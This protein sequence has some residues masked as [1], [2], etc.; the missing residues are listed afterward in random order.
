MK[1]TSLDSTESEHCFDEKSPTW[2]C[3]IPTQILAEDGG[4]I[5]NGDLKIVAEVVGVPDVSE[6]SI[7]LRKFEVN[8]FHVFPSQVVS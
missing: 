1:Y 2:E 6:E 3:A 8:G 7:S 5:E 4:F